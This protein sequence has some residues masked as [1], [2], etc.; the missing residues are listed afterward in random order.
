MKKRLQIMKPILAIAFVAILIATG[1]FM[2]DSWLPLLQ[3][4]KTTGSDNPP[5]TTTK[6]GDKKNAASEQIILSDQ[7]IANLGLKVKSIQPETFWKTLQVPGMVVDRPGRSDRGLVSPVDGVVE[8]MNYFPGA[9]TSFRT[10]LDSCFLDDI[11][12]SLTADPGNTEFPKF[13]QDT[14]IAEPCFPGDLE[15]QFSQ[16][17]TLSWSTNELSLPP[18]FLFPYPAMKSPGCEDR[19]QFI[20]RFSERLAIFQELSTFVRFRMNF[21]WNTVP[22]NPVLIFQVEDVFGQQTVGSSRYQCQQGMKKLEHRGRI[23]L[24]GNML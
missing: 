3:Q 10:R 20:N 18:S 19:N 17:G 7:A 9:G 16:Y 8:K 24:G 22:Q 21:T 15:I 13:T 11:F 14:S 2:R 5:A 1:Y 23:S 6:A 4:N 12:H